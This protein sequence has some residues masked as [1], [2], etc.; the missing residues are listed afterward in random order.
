M[1]G[2]VGLI[3]YPDVRVNID[4]AF[5]RTAAAP[6]E[7]CRFVLAVKKQDTILV[8]PSDGRLE[9]RIDLEVPVKVKDLVEDQESG[10]ES[11]LVTLIVI[12]I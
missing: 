5:E 1:C 2:D 9:N 11:K 3:Q 12:A 7:C 6:Q 8:Y 10:L 4:F